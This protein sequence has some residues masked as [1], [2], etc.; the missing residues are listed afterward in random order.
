MYPPSPNIK[1]WDGMQSFSG[2]AIEAQSQDESSKEALSQ[3]GPCQIPVLGPLGEAV[4]GRMIV[5]LIRR[6]LQVPSLSGTRA[7]AIYARGRRVDWC[8]PLY[9]DGERSA[10]AWPAPLVRRQWST[11]L[12]SHGHLSRHILSEIEVRITRAAIQ[13]DTQAPLPTTGSRDWGI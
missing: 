6:V 11:L 5:R 1:A 3:Q 12:G 4:A 13:L 9:L 10:R 7:I 8:N 2:A